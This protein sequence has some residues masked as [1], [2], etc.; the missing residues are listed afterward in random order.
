MSGMITKNQHSRAR[1]QWL[2]MI[3]KLVNMVYYQF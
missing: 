1:K 2:Y 3:T